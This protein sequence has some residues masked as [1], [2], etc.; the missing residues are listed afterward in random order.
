M[1]ASNPNVLRGSIRAQI[2]RHNDIYTEEITQ[3]GRTIVAQ[4]TPSP[5]NDRSNAKNPII[6]AYAVAMV[7]IYTGKYE[8]F[9]ISMTMDDI[10]TA[11]SQGSSAGAVAQK[12]TG[13]MAKKT[14]V[15][16]L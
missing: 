12:F 7:K 13:E 15:N 1:Y 4:H 9:V 11:W 14:V 16:R 6:A 10:K 3:D 8:P 5:I 2:I